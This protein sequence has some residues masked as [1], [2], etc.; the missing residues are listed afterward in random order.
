LK[1]F[2]KIVYHDFLNSY[3]WQCDCDLLIKKY[4]MCFNFK[5]ANIFAGRKINKNKQIIFI[6]L[7]FTTNYAI[8]KVIIPI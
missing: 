3:Y 4:F 6:V 5:L 2:N 1:G 7:V 8:K